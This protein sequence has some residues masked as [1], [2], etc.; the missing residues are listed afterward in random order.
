[1]GVLL[2]KYSIVPSIKLYA[3]AVYQILLVDASKDGS[4]HGKVSTV[5]ALD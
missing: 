5:V 3:E 4:S 1:M 2:H